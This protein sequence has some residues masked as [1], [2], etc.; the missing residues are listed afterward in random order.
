M[1]AQTSLISELEAAIA[2]GGSERR[3]EA[4]RRVTDLFL[5]NADR[6]EPEQIELFDDVLERI[7]SHIERRALAELGRRLAPVN[8]APPRVMR[9]LAMND[10]IEVAGPVIESSNRLST[11]DL[12]NIASTKSQHHLLAICGRKEIDEAITDVLVERGN[13]DVARKVA[14]NQGARFSGPGYAS[15]VK[16]AEKDDQLIE[17]I[18]RRSDISPQLFQELLR[19]ATATVRARLLA[20]R[21]DLGDGVSN[22]V[23]RA[24]EELAKANVARDYSLAKRIV[25]PLHHDRVLSEKVIM[26]FAR[27]KRLEEVIVA[28]SLLCSSELDIIDRLMQGS[29]IDAVLIPCKSA[30]FTW[31]AAKAVLQLNPFHRALSD[32]RFRQLYNDYQKLSIATAKRII[33]FW[34]LRSKT[35]ALESAEPFPLRFD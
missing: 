2:S 9:T 1:S 11:P 25:Q 4:L 28:L 24:S 20:V 34:Q 17:T 35:D 3:I 31:P 8:N 5:A 30:D 6:Y 15:L 32:E 29:Q 10:A 33:R 23:Q 14:A 16:R 22:A 19:Q 12:V 26:D 27:D 18:G 7:A 21:P 13:A